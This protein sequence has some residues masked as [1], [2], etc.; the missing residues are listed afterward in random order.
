[1]EYSLVMLMCVII[2]YENFLLK[3]KLELA[4]KV[5]DGAEYVENATK[6]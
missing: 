3:L 4:E 5:K 1:M 6:K 2:Q